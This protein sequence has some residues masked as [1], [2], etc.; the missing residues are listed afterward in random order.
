[1]VCL[2]AAW[3]RTCESYARSFADLAASWGDTVQALWLDIEDH[4]DWLDGLEVETFPTLL[5]ARDDTVLFYGPVL[6]QPGAAAQLV[7]RAGQDGWPAVQDAGA[8]ALA[9]RLH[10]AYLAGVGANTAAAGVA[11]AAA[12]LSTLRQAITST[13]TPEGA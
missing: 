7:A 3:C 10:Q 2:C 4:E 13:A 8:R 1:M 11:P 9:R 6:P 12:R 5:I